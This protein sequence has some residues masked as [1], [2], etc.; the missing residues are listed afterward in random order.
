MLKCRFCKC[1]CD[2]SDLVNGICDDCR[3][4]EQKEH[5]WKEKIERLARG[6]YEQME[7]KI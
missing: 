6:R 2:P 1:N 3:E 4:E 5:E 7:L